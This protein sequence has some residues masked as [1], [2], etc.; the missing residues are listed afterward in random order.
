[1]ILAGTTAISVGT[2]NIIRSQ[3]TDDSVPNHC[4]SDCNSLDAFRM[5]D[6]VKLPVL[7]LPYIAR[8]RAC[9][10]SRRCPPEGDGDTRFGPRTAAGTD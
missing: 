1:M 10:C 3:A 5:T 6:Q 2:R 4:R 7:T 9:G 8:A